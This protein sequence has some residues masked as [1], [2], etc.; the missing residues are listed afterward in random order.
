MS[1]KC[2]TN[3]VTKTTPKTNW[4]KLRQMTDEDVDCSDIPATDA[5]FWASAK[6]VIPEAKVSL[7]IRFDRDV[8]NWFKKQGPGYQTRM[9]AVL[10]AYMDNQKSSHLRR[11]A[12]G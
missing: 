3:G 7:G 8:V 11:K 4:D 6:L 5:K 12:I 2:T 1:K 10:R 9:N